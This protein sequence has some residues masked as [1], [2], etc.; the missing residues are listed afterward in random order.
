MSIE[1]PVTQLAPNA[2]RPITVAVFGRRCTLTALPLERLARSSVSVRMVVLPSQRSFGPSVRMITA[3]STIPLMPNINTVDVDSVDTIAA[4]HSIPIAMVRRPLSDDLADLIEDLAVDLIVVSCFPWRIPRSVYRR[5]RL[6]AINLHPSPLPRFR[7]PDPLFWAFQ[8]ATQQWGVTVH[9]V[10]QQLDAG[11]IL[12]RQSIQITDAMSGIAL[13]RMC[14]ETGSLVLLR[15]ADQIGSNNVIEEAQNDS[16]ATYF[17]FPETH[18][19]RISPGWTVRRTL[20]FVTGLPSLGYSPLVETGRGVVKVLGAT[21]VDEGDIESPERWV[22]TN[23]VRLRLLDG[24]I[25]LS[26]STNEI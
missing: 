1:G 23:L 19:L 9:R 8:T 4:R 22:R 24:W 10:T 18:D 17:G 15:V 14:A 11:P 2:P 26:V 16:V 13:E 3:R 25:D 7:G 21:D 5:A 20:N 12:G 6:G